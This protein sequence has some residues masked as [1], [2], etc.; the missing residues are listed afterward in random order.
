MPAPLRF[1]V[2]H[3]PLGRGPRSRRPGART[4][5]R[6]RRASRFRW[7]ARRSRAATPLQKK[8]CMI[9]GL[10]IVTNSGPEHA[11]GR[12][13]RDDD[14]RQRAREDRPAGLGGGRRLDRSA[15]ARELADARRADADEQD[16]VRIAAARR[17][18]PLR[19]RRGRA[20]R[21]VVQGARRRVR[22][23]HAPPAALSRRR[24]RST[25]STG[26]SA[27]LCRPAPTR[28]SSSP[29]SSRSATSC[30]RTSR[31]CRR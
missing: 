17:G 18:H 14:R 24:S 26:S 11:R 4:R 5:P 28:R 15:A 23:R 22:H 29:R 12:D 27:A 21:A 9:D 30:A 6:R 8:M 31:A 7:R 1:L 3:H 13:G 20:A 16:D 2:I 10:N 25:S 19:P